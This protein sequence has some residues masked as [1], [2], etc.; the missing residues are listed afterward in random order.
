MSC[1]LVQRVH[2]SSPSVPKPREAFL[3]TAAAL[4]DMDTT[5]D[6]SGKG[7]LAFSPR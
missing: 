1:S 4:A 2:S 3:L 5:L 6:D 7:E